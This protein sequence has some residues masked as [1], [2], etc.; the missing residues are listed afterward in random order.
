[1]PTI[2]EPATRDS[3]VPAFS[4]PELVI[5]AGRTAHIGDGFWFKR[6]PAPWCSVSWLRHGGFYTFER[7]HMAH[8]ATHNID[9]PGYNVGILSK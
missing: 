7:E 1:M 5:P 2:C 9:V 6:C 4:Y 8:A 3:A